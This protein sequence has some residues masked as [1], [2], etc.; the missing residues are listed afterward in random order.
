MVGE[1]TAE[2][3]GPYGRLTCPRR[4][5][6]TASSIFKG[7]IVMH[8]AGG[9]IARLPTYLTLLLVTVVAVLPAVAR[10]AAAAPAAAVPRP[11]GAAALAAW[12]TIKY[13]SSGSAVTYLQQRL[14]A[15]R[16]DVGSVDGVF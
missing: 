13:G 16:Y 3:F 4:L 12:P 5:G 1:V 14:S 11:L 10:P 6:E 2:T 7:M 8:S 9:R 15:L